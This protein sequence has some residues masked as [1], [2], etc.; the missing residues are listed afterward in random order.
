MTAVSLPREWV[1]AHHKA[2]SGPQ[3]RACLEEYRRGH[4]E[5]AAAARAEVRARMKAI[6]AHPDAKGRGQMA[7]ALAF[8]TDLSVDQAG[9]LLRASPEEAPPRPLNRL[10]AAIRANGGT[11]NVGTDC[12]EFI[13]TASADAVAKRIVRHVNE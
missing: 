10:D 8:D 9:A 2:M 7:Q 3:M 12:M 1:E 5:G 13:E 4:A 6:L 11:P